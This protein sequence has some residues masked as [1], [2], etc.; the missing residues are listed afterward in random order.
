MKK[1]EK[2]FPFQ[3]YYIITINCI[4]INHPTVS[5]Y[6]DEKRDTDASRR[7]PRCADP[8]KGG[9][10]SWEGTR[11][12]WRGM[13]DGRCSTLLPGVTCR[14]SANWS[15]SVPSRSCPWTTSSTATRQCSAPA[16]LPAHQKL[17]RVN[18]QVSAPLSAAIA[19]LR[20][21]FPTA[22]IRS[23]AE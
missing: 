23:M 17:T 20:R 8:D 4:I 16:C 2:N 14:R 18:W 13:N 3:H 1:I 19:T 21:R 22:T 11:C 5:A 9:L 6:P 12:G 15:V 7:A 10:S